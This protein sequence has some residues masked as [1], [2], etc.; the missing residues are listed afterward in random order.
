[1]SIAE[2]HELPVKKKLLLMEV[3][4]EDLRSHVGHVPVPQW[5][6]ELL[7]AR[8]AAVESGEEQILDW[9]EVKGTLGTRRK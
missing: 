2:I 8:R 4:W 6:K 1:M 5:H 9:D 7:D 3:L